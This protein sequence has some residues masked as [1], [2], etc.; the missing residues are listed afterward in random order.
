MNDYYAGG[1]TC[2]GCG[3]FVMNNITHICNVPYPPQ[4][5]APTSILLEAK[6]DPA[7]L[8]RLDEIIELLKKIGRS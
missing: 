5:P 3:A 6:T 8:N 7:I 2:A 4:V 1:Y